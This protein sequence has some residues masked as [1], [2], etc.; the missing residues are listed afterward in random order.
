MTRHYDAVVIGAGFSG[1]YALKKLQNELG[2]TAR[3]FEKAAGVGGTWY[4]NAFPGALSDSE[5]HIYCY[6]HD[7]QMLADREF[8]TKYI[9]QPDVLQY[10][11]SAVDRWGLRDSIELANGVRGARFEEASN[12]WSVETEDGACVTAKYLVTAIGVLSAPNLPRIPGLDSFEGEIVHAGRSVGGVEYRGKRV[13]VV[14]TGSTGVQVITAVAPD[15]EH[16]T[17]FQRSAQYTVPIGNRAL[18]ASEVQHIK[19]NYDQIWDQVMKSSVAFGFDE[20]EVLYGSVGDGERQRIFEEAWQLGGGF[21]FMF[22]TFKDLVT[23]EDAN[24]G[25]QAFI[26]A[27]IAEIVEDPETARKLTPTEPYAKRPLCDGGYYATFNRANV[28]L[29][30]TR[31]NDIVEVT[32]SGVKTADGQHRDLDLLIFATG[33]DAVEGSFR[34]MD[35]EGRNGVTLTSYWHDTGPMSYLGMAMPNVPNLFMVLGPGSAF[36]N[37]PPAIETQVEWISDLIGR[38]EQDGSSSVEAT[39]ESAAEWRQTCD[40]LASY[41]LF[42]KTPSWIF[43]GNIPGKIQCA[44]FFFGGLGAYRETIAAEAASDY[45]NFIF[46][47]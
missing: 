3:V 25:A 2:L 41:T 17:V 34:A 24:R 22:G 36:S 14:G 16:L 42:P 35:I 44:V 40:V 5:T 9:A 38:A 6:S 30:D 13:G 8:S 37:I 45:K 23:D 21:R 27:K 11:E 1:I 26:K 46:R 28:E 39:P 32:G 18:T 43:G 29:V 19:D 31:A 7:K 47:Q 10:L 20:S 33:F 4:W 12:L 15:V